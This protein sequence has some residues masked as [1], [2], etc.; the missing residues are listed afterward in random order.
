MIKHYGPQVRLLDIDHQSYPGLS[1]YRQPGSYMVNSK[2]QI[3]LSYVVLKQHGHYIFDM[4]K[5][6]GPQVRLLDIDHQSYPSPPL[7]RQPGSI[8]VNNKV[9]L[10]FPVLYFSSMGIISL[11]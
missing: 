1:P 4:I 10:H 7:Y 5:H 9:R 6:Y 3:S 8:M 2:I 11:T